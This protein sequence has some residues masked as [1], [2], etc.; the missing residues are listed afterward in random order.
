M[1]SQLKCV[2]KSTMKDNYMLA[3][4]DTTALEPIKCK[5]SVEESITLHKILLQFENSTP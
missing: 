5:E 1:A 3:E 2:K 4:D